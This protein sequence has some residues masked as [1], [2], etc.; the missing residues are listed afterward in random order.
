[1]HVHN[2]DIK[3]WDENILKLLLRKKQCTKQTLHQYYSNIKTE[4]L[5]GSVVK[6]LEFITSIRYLEKYQYSVPCFD[7]MGKT[8]IYCIAEFEPAY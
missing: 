4:V 1:M 5:W 6:K 8:A 3:F 7:T 2:M